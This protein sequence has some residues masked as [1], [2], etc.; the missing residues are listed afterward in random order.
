MKQASSLL[1]GVM[2]LAF[3][4]NSAELISNG[5]FENVPFAMSGDGSYCYIGSTTFG[6]AGSL[7]G[8]SGIF[9]VI[10]SNSPAF[11]SSPNTA[12]DLYEVG[13]KVGSTITQTVSIPTN[14]AYQLSWS[15]AGRQFYGTE[16]YQVS[17]GAVVLAT[18]STIGGQSWS[19]HTVTFS[20]NAGTSIL[21]FAGNS[22]T[23]S[24]AFI[25][26]VSLTP[27]PEL[28]TSAL[29][30]SGLLVLVLARTARHRSANEA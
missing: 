19:R 25:D 14:G 13:V 27:V 26:N 29:F 4:A 6:C 1:L 5:S 16:N 9:V 17:F 3:N 11:S 28:A 2:S 23:D 12:S 8:W 10:K 7:L 21:S 22:Q 15:D 20:A 30:V 18:L 24:T